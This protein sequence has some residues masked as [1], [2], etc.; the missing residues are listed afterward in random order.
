MTGYEGRLVRKIFKG[1]VATFAL[2]TASQGMARGHISAKL[3]HSLAGSETALL[4]TV[5]NDGDAPIAM[6]KEQIPLVLI[7]GRNLPSKLFDVRDADSISDRPVEYTGFLIHQKTFEDDAFRVLAPGERIQVN[8]DP[9][10]DF[11]L[12]ASHK[13]HIKYVASGA[14]H[15]TDTLG[16]A[17]VSA[18][19]IGE[20]ELVESNVIELTTSAGFELPRTFQVHLPSRPGFDDEAGEPEM[21]FTALLA[22]ANMTAIARQEYVA[23][24]PPLFFRPNTYSVNGGNYSWW[25]GTYNSVDENSLGGMV[26]AL[27]SRLEMQFHGTNP[28]RPV[29]FVNGRSTAVCG[30]PATAAV[31]HTESV[32][33]N[34]TYEIVICPENFFTLP[35][36]PDGVRPASQ[37]GTLVHEIS[38]FADLPTD[39]GGWLGQTFDLPPIT[40][41]TRQGAH[42]LA[43]QNRPDAMRNASN[44]EFYVENKPAH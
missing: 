44:F 34:G 42:N 13:Y 32:A 39:A 20:Q 43:G 38:H 11:R 15:P 41:Y 24:E 35:V 16:R 25:F 7:N 31:A 2:V 30:N 8:Y 12:E 18:L 29:V 9:A 37:G 27:R 4:L 21:L 1:A 17:K 19:P 22:A 36:Y 33:T 6:L 28:I 5:A 14:V 3:E 10:N 23:G 26:R 40:N